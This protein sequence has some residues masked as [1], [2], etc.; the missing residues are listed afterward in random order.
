MGHGFAVAAT[1]AP[2]IIRASARE[3]EALG[4]TSFWVNHP[5]KIDGLAAL[6]VAAAE[7]RRIQLGVG[8]IPL[9]TREPASIV[10]GVRAH[11]LPLGRLLLGVGSPNPGALARVHAGIAELRTQLRARLVVAALGPRMCQL[12][13]ELADGVLFNWLTPEHARVSA[14]LVRAGAATMGRQPPKLCA[15]VRVALG[16]GAA[17]RLEAEAARYAGIPAYASHFQRMGVRPSDTAIAVLSPDAI[18]P[19]LARWRGVVDEIVIRA[20]TDKDTVEENL[21]LVQAARPAPGG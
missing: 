1:T 21:A 18:L 9:H 7:T 2:E 15:Y 4:Y 11:A 3:A 5:G 17:V 19:G 13:G 6:A 14:D 12:A 10:E 16:Q 20:V 8:V